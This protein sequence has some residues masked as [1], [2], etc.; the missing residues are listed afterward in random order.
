MNEGESE[1]I[2]RPS[3]PPQKDGERLVN[4]VVIARNDGTR[5]KGYVWDFNPDDD[6][7]HLFDTDDPSEPSSAV[8]K[9]PECKAL[10]FVRSLT[11]NPHFQEDKEV[12]PEQKKFGRAYEVE[13]KDGEH[14]RGTVEFYNPRRKGFYLFPSDSRSNSLRIFVV[15]A[16]C[17]EV[18]PIQAV[19]GAKADRDWTAPDPCRYPME[20][21]VEVV[22][23]LA[24]GEDPGKLSLD[25]LLPVPIIEHWRSAF[26]AGGGKALTDEALAQR[27]HTADPSSPPPKP[28][29]IPVDRRVEA[30]VR[31]IARQNEG[32][33]SQVFLAPLHRIAEWRDAFVDAGSMA[34]RN[35]A[36]EE[37][38]IDEEVL[39]GRYE[40][41]IAN[42]E[43]TISERDELLDSLADILGEDKKP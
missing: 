35:Q 4:K 26:L 15:K 2:G 41:I 30:V 12:P 36:V 9:V 7:F 11:G 32:V 27:A 14:I 19:A 16:A 40:H 43:E 38:Q 1:P 18:R 13:F 20:K 31:T 3:G 28:D 10:Y 24:K 22:L 23:R 5:F 21:R 42:R 17:K 39:R 37:K 33:V 25:V 34:V 8:L 29:R 6:K